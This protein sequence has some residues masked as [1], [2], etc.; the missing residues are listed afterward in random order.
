MSSEHAILVVEDDESLRGAIESFLGAAGFATVVYASAEAMLVG[1][2]I[3][4]ALCIV[5]DLK[6]PAM[7]GFQ[8]L[9]ALQARATRPPVILIT[10]H[11]SPG[12]RAEARRHGAAG[13][14]AK[15]FEGG[16]LLAAIDRATG[17]VQSEA[18]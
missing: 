13:Y 1:G 12:T 6:L 17:A 7:S 10:A 16:A 3:D 4:D 18:N 2:A 15:P 14:L 9:D 11:D 5:S 8:L